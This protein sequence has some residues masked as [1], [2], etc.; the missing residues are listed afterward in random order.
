MSRYKKILIWLAVIFVV[1]SLVGFFVIPPIAKSV[2]IDKA[3]QALHR[4]VAVKEISFNPYTFAVTVRGLEIKEPKGPDVFVSF[5]E[6]FINLD[7]WS[8]FRRALTITDITLKKPYARI[9]RNVDNTYNFSDLI[10]KPPEAKEVKEEKEK[11]SEP[12]RFSLN[13]IKI[14]Q[15]AIDFN[16]GPKHTNHKITDIVVAIPFISNR[17]QRIDKYTQ[18]VISATVNG[19]PYALKGKT[20]PFSDSLATIFDIKIKDFN[21]PYYIAYVPMET[22][23]KLKSAMLDTDLELSFSQFHDKKKKPALSLKGDVVLKNFILDD[24]KGQPLVRLPALNVTIADAQPLVPT[25]HFAKIALTTPDVTI[26]RD[27]NGVINLLSI[28]PEKKAKEGPEKKKEPA[29]RKGAGKEVAAKEAATTDA[30]KEKAAGP[31]PLLTVD[32]FAITDGTVRFKDETPAQPVS[33]TLAKLN[34]A[35]EKFSTRKDT[36]GSMNLTAGYDKKGTLSAAGPFGIDPLTADLDVKLTDIQ[37]RTIQGYFNDKIKINVTSGGITAGGKVAIAHLGEKGLSAKYNGKI[38][39]SR[40]NSIDKANADTFLKWKS[41]YFNDVRAGY[42]PLS[43]DIR[44]IALADFLANIIINE[45]GSLNLQNIM[46]KGEAGK[47]G[48]EKAE[49]PAEK[50]KEEAVAA[51]DAKEKEK[52]VPIKIGAITLQNGTVD[53][54]DRHIKPNYQSHMTAIGGRVAGLSSLVEK[55]ADVELRGKFEQ[56]MPLEITGKINPLGKDLFV[57]IKASFK[58]MDLSPLTPY[59]GRYVGHTIQK[60]KLSFDLKYLIVQKK[61]N[62]E[63]KIFVDQLT[64]GDKVASP[65]ATKLP[66][67]LAIALLRD[68]NGQINLDVPVTGSTDDPKFSIMRLVIQVIVNLITKAVTA[69]FALLGNLFGGGEEMSYV[70]FDYGLSTITD[71]SQKKIDNLAKALYERPALKL[72]IEG[73]ADLDRDREGLKHYLIDR[74]MK[75]RKLNDMV[76]QGQRAVPVDKV[77]IEPKE[78]EKYLTQV[79]RAESFPKP[80]N[81]IGLV[82][83]LPVPE[84][85]KLLMTYTVVKEPDLKLLASQRA[86]AVRDAIL[87]SGKVEPERVF[88]VEPKSLAPDKKEKAKNSRVDFKLK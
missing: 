15:G 55:P 80:R 81:V 25:L 87:K 24:K 45:D 3:S 6:L 39:I 17:E 38:L 7:T 13:N 70:E 12:L 47:P 14:E 68:R 61:L 56:H 85:E 28:L 16:D 52:P 66:V 9:I 74:K 78:Y 2:L 8:V 11:K 1:F 43:V 57:D 82:K 77:T 27:K 67:G 32:T 59:S 76:A 60:G 71:Q 37:I 18:P 72:D 21:V 44:Q 23:F 31:P 83:T 54:L 30:A 51:K 88:V 36:K 69:P 49:T 41:L 35:V 62:S 10:V 19:T 53:F 58:D 22:N 65:E 34:L 73:H 5:D 26:H 46:E 20:K 29:R 42:N 84:M 48:A 86:S 4:P 63:N 50:K 33:V 64:L 40:F 75:A 79:Y